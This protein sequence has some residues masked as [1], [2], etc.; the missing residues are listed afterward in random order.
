MNLVLLRKLMG[1]HS[2]IGELSINGV[3]ECYTLEDICRPNGIKVYGE[4]A[5]PDGTYEVAVTWSPRFQR[6]LPLLMQVNGYVGVRIHPGN[7]SSDTEGC[8][9]VGSS[10]RGHDWIGSSQVTFK[11][12]FAKIEQAKAIGEHIYLKV[13]NSP[14]VFAA[15][16]EQVSHA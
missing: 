14:E 10:M 9:L 16:A 13:I 15:M 4:T 12:L 3:F 8:I 7:K 6:M 2:T 1:D 11:A 5:I